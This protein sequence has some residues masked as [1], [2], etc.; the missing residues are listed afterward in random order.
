MMRLAVENNLTNNMASMD[1]VLD[2]VSTDIKCWQE[3][4]KHSSDNGFLCC[5]GTELPEYFVFVTFWALLHSNLDSLDEINIE[6][7]DICPFVGFLQ[8]AAQKPLV[9]HARI[10]NRVLRYVRR[11]PSGMLFQTAIS[12]TAGSRCRCG[13]QGKAPGPHSCGRGYGVAR[14]ALGPATSREHLN[15]LLK[16]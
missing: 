15:L 16:K 2:Q 3:N 1:S 11:V 12:S 6:R 4:T 14:R 7:A 5:H 9:R 13:I 8:R 10:I